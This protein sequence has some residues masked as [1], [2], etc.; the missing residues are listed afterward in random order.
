MWIYY[1]CNPLKREVNDCVVRSISLAEGRDWYET[2]DIL[3]EIAK[4]DATILDDIMLVEKYL[5]EKYEEICFKCR[6]KRIKVK[7]FL[8]DNPK[9]VYLITMRGHITCAIDGIVYDIW[10]CTDKL[11]WNVWKVC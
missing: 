1:N 9:G 8:F 3:T 11:I 2:Y 10:D 4:K 7:E 6:G 5:N